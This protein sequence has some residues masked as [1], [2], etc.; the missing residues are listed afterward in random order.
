MINLS[1]LPD[2]TF[3]L[4]DP[5]L[6]GG[7]AFTVVRQSR[8]LSL[9]SDASVT[10]EYIPATGNIQPAQPEDLQQLPEEQRHET[11]IVIR[12]TF[13]FRLASDVNGVQHLPDEIDYHGNRWK[14][15][16]VDQ[17]AAWGFTTAWATLRREVTV[18]DNAN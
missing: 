14:V 5:A 8:V 4:D 1:N 17:W 12:S 2:V 3:L 10:T 11:V 13:K 7:V 18:N 6:G 15:T 16:R 9:L